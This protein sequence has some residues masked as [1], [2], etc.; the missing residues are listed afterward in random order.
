M[1]RP[2]INLPP[3]EMARLVR[4]YR[5]GASTNA[6]SKQFGISDYTIL[7]ILR[8]A[9][10]TIRPRGKVAIADAD[11]RARIVAEYLAGASVRAIARK[12]HHNEYVIRYLLE[13]E[14]AFAKARAL[15]PDED[16]KEQTPQVWQ[17]AAYRQRISGGMPEHVARKVSHL[18]RFDWSQ[19][20]AVMAQIPEA[21]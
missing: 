1:G 12:W 14:D 4:L 6:L 9:K 17:V 16:E 3:A 18:E 5:K 10:I 19:V 8:T 20:A 13:K 7:R 11:K 15:A 2:L 21:M